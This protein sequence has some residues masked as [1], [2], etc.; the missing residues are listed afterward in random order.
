MSGVQKLKLAAIKLETTY[1]TDAFGGTP[2]PGEWFAVGQDFSV[3]PVLNLVERD[4]AHAT[5]DM[6]PAMPVPSHTDV[7]IPFD[8]KGAGVAGD[9]PAWDALMR[10]S[11]HE[12]D[13][14]GATEVVYSPSTLIDMTTA[15]SITV[16]LY[17][18]TIDTGEA[19]LFKATGVRGGISFAGSEGQAVRGTFTGV[20]AWY[21]EGAFGAAPADPTSYVLSTD[22][23]V[24]QGA[25]CTLGGNGCELLS[26]EFATRG[27]PAQRRAGTAANGLAEVTLV[28][29]LPTI[30]M[31]F[32][33]STQASFEAIR[34]AYVTAATI[35]WS[36]DL[37][38]GVV[39]AAPFMQFEAPGKSEGA[40]STYPVN[41]SAR[42]DLSS[43]G[44]DS[45]TITVG[46][47]A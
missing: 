2:A 36:L 44:D 39:F 14:T 10:A 22:Y 37:G 34:A 15:P 5:G 4:L 38:S 31:E 43:G 41:A 24:F 6:L 16:Y 32:G 45:Y 18:L 3:S 27:E 7:V 42:S 1:N 30:S 35:A 17:E 46:A 11:G 28:P 47:A 8:L 13:D 12:R 19:K 21:Q 25:T 9:P 40:P 23:T 20:G 29:R 26:F 33:R